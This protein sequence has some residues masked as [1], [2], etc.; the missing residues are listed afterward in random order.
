[1]Y[2]SC[3]NTHTP[4]QSR[5]TSKVVKHLPT[6]TI[7]TFYHPFEPVPTPQA[8]LKT[9]LADMPINKL[10]SFVCQTSSENGRKSFALINPGERSA[11]WPHKGSLT[12]WQLY[13]PLNISITILNFLGQLQL[14]PNWVLWE[15][16]P[17]RL[18]VL[19]YQGFLLTNRLLLKF[20]SHLSS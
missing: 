15:M 10:Q 17:G 6:H 1:M 7:F 4:T 3:V 18:R 16:L 14:D 20:P 12:S 9:M 13:S 8:L 11:A 2:V 19:Y 5:P